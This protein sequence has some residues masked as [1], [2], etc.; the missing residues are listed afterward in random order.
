MSITSSQSTVPLNVQVRVH[1]MC[2][3]DGKLCSVSFVFEPSVAKASFP[4]LARL[5]VAKASFP[6][7]APLTVAKVSFLYLARLTVAKASFPYLAR[8]TAAKASFSYLAH[9]TVAK[10]SFPYRK[11]VSLSPKHLFF[12]LARLT[13]FISLSLGVERGG[14][15]RQQ[16][17]SYGER[18]GGLLL[19]AG[20]N[21][22]MDGRSHREDSG[23]AGRPRFC[24]GPV[25][26]LQGGFW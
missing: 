1:A 2:W 15:M 19:P 10:A 17:G 20:G 8:L 23:P 22:P 26:H 21:G 24:G 3:E 18:P 11:P 4:Y 7:L 6:Y 14:D 9:L 5:T 25:Q 13:L 12:Y 16:D